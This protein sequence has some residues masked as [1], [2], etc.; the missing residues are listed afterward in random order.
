VHG[1]PSFH[2]IA[3]ARYRDGKLICAPAHDTESQGGR[4][5]THRGRWKQGRAQCYDRRMPWLNADAPRNS[6]SGRA[7]QPNNRTGDGSA[8]GRYLQR[9]RT[10]RTGNW[11]NAA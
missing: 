10:D 7:D 4:K 9:E 2:S 6:G 11:R 5:A 8:T 1:S 3:C